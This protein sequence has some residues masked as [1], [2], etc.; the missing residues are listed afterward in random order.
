MDILIGLL[1]GIFIYILIG[2]IFVLLTEA[3]ED[4]KKEIVKLIL[5]WPI[6]LLAFIFAFLYFS[7]ITLKKLIFDKY[8][9]EN[10]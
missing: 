6:L 5:G 4:G 3:Y 10:K 2:I 1:I 7:F 9:L 8:K